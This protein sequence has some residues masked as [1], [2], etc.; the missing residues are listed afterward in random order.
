LHDQGVD[1]II[2]ATFIPI[3]NPPCN[4]LELI[5]KAAEEAMRCFIAGKGKDPF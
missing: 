2:P 1:A 4:A 5:E 3:D